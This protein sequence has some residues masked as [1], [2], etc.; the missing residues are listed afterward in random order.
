MTRSEE[1]VSITK[2]AV[3][4]GLEELRQRARWIELVRSQK[5]A[6]QFDGDFDTLSE[7]LNHLARQRE[8][9]DRLREAERK[10]TMR[11][12]ENA[13]YAEQH[14]ALCHA[15][16]IEKISLVEAVQMVAALRAEREG[17]VLVPREPSEKMVASVGTVL[18]PYTAKLVWQRMLAAA[19]EESS[20]G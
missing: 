7:A 6:D 8:E 19:E 9:L 12:L 5:W 2:S 4:E 15:L 14:E 18:Q 3:E 17:M 10:H 16:G 20:R 13:L 11:G 1:D